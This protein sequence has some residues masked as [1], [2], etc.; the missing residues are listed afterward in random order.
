MLKVW[1]R[2]TSSNVQK[3]MWAVAE[4]GLEHERID[5]GGSF[6]GLDTP[7]FGALNPNRLIPVIDDGG[8]VIWESHAIVRYLAAR[9][10]RGTLWPEDPGERARADQWMDWLHTTVWPDLGRIFMGLVRTPPSRRDMQ[11][12]AEAAERLG[13]TYAILDRALEGRAYLLGDE[14]G[15]GDIPLGTSLYRYYTLEP[16]ERPRLANLEAWYRR[17]QARPAYAE[18][19]MVSYESLRVGD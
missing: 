2:R 6:G 7:E 5:V 9:Y 19:A 15:M 18:H 4:L 13:R 8:V 12:I 3:V 17:L 11:A 1:G 16:V 10:G 14:L